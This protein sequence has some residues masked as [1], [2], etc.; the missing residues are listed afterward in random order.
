MSL[1]EEATSLCFLEPRIYFGGPLSFLF[2]FLFQLHPKHMEILGPGIE[3]KPQ[4]QQHWS[5]NPLCPIG[6]AASH[7]QGK[8]S[9]RILQLSLCI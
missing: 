6:T 1:L 8:Y 2:F 4:L 7:F 3:S 9:V 5:L